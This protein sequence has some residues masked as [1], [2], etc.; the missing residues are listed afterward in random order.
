MTDA[1]V[2]RRTLLVLLATLCI[3]G[4]AATPQKP[5]SR[6]HALALEHNRRGVQAEARG[7]RDRALSEFNEAL[8]LQGA[9]DNAE[10]MVVALVN[11]ARTQRLKGDLQSAGSSVERALALLPEGSALGSELFFEKAKV[12]H[13][14]G[15][16]AAATGWAVRAE[17]GAK[18]AELGRRLN[19][20]ALLK[21]RQG[22]VK[23]AAEVLER[24]LPLNGGGAASAEEANSLRLLGEVALLQG[25]HDKAFESYRAAL[26]LDQELGLGKKIAA[27][28]AGLGGVAAARGDTAGA[29]GWY[30]RAV[31]VSKHGG[32]ADGA[33]AAAAKLAQLYGLDPSAVHASSPPR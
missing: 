16:I 10:G 9:V 15:E 2:R 22:E 26:A 29:I 31:E 30:R 27:D 12:L 32:D 18:G 6:P 14:A 13:A 11:I 23:Q 8:R 4:C 19:L 25:E 33:A 1:R 5:V 24:A 17:A 21:L 20:V 7:D 28:L 3:C